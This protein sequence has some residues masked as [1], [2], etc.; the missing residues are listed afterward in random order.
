[1]PRSDQP[2]I[3]GPQ[4]L[5]RVLRDPARDLR[6]RYKDDPVGLA[7]H[8]HLKLPRKP[9]QIMKDLGVY[10]P[11]RHG[12]IEP[13]I[14][15]LIEDVCSG[16]IQ[17]AAVVGPR[18]GGKSMGVSFIEFKLVFIDDYDALNLGG[19]ELQAD[20][21]YQYLLGYIDSDPYWAS[22]VKGDPMRERTYTQNDAWIRVLTA[23]QKSVRSPH[24]GG[25]KKDGRLAGGLLVID[26]EAEAAPD[27][28]GAALPTVNTARPSV[29]VRSS[30]FHN[31]EGTFA[32]LIDNHEEMGF[33]L[34]RWDIFDVC[35][36]C[37][38][39]GDACESD[40]KCFREDHLEDYVD[41]DTGEAKQKLLHKAYCGGRAKYADG[42]IPMREVVRLWRRM[43][44]NHSQW[45]VEAM[46]SRPSTSGHVIKSV[47][48][49][50]ANS[51]DVNASSL[52]LP[53]SAITICVDWGTVAAGVEVWQEQPYD[54]HV[55]LHADQ[56]EEAGPTQILGVI[57]GYWNMY[58]NDVTE[59][60]ADIG[61]GGN[62][63][64]KALVEDHAIPVRDVNFGEEKEAAAAAWN[65][66]NEAGKL[67]LPKEFTEF[68]KQVRAWKRK[69]GRI[70]K[71][72]DHMCDAA[73]C[74]FAKFIDRLGLTHIRVPPRAF[75]ASAAPP[76]ISH[77]RHSSEPS[78]TRA[79]IRTVG[80]GRRKR[81]RGFR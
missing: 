5:L 21:V 69:N 26:E 63:M 61:G 48:H 65:M 57:L 32:E 56:V 34:Y 46:G 3:P 1:M 18:G 58:L 41:P 35:E 7:E 67:V 81:P 38:C 73:I 70:Q 42:W 59:V 15:D 74:Y 22:L 24:A 40:E 36:R 53:G 51:V 75:N 31:N 66:Y 44:K 78:R 60:A 14:R 37:E 50:Q 6:E 10:D 11:E 19:S 25:R 8:F 45:E 55:L 49:H 71:G 64:N 12:P 17:D 20:Q 79:M 27:I 16:E 9:V 72:N 29:V 2:A 54:K 62:Y 76:T 4:D 47:A 30:T 52:Y 80:S 43:K 77:D 33:K 13:G 68:H 39:T 23:S 28:V